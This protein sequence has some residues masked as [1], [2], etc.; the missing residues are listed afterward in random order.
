M[1]KKNRDQRRMV[2]KPIYYIAISKETFIKKKK[3]NFS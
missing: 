3:Q 1:Y 2:F